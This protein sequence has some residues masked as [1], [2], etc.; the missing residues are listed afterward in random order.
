MPRHERPLTTENG[1]AAKFAAGL[2]ELRR[3]AGN[4]PYRE[5]GRR[6][7]YSAGTLSDAAAGRKLPSLSV[8]LAYVRACGGDVPEWEQRWH[9]ANADQAEP[10]QSESAGPDEHQP[11]VGLAAF[12]LDDADRFF[13]REALVDLVA[14]RVAKHRLVGVFGASGAGK[15]SLLQAGLEP[16]LA[17]G[18]VEVILFTPGPDP[19]LSY[20]AR[21]AD[22]LER[23]AEDLRAQLSADEGGLRQAVQD[24]QGAPAELILIVDQFEEVFTLGADEVARTR[25]IDALVAAA[26]AEDSR[27]RVI[28][29]VGADFY[30]HCTAHAG[31]VEMLRDAQIAVG[32]MSAAELRQAI[33]QSAHRA[34]C[35]VE[36]AL[37]AELV[38]HTHGRAGVL[39]LLS[40]ALRETWR[41]R[42]GNT[43]TV[44]GF[45]ATGGIDGALARTAETCYTSLRPRQQERNSQ[46]SL[47]PSMRSHC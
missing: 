44:A 36:G 41:R 25:F 22:V 9:E 16:W 24:R 20:A 40:H 14:H 13:G 37:V 7:H 45:Q 8:A 34:G 27:L 47:S 21:L 18:D 19:L 15:S 11:Y 29:G 23:D 46:A 42:R 35:T 31:L 3:M 28:L 17:S 10:D 1:T 39:P 32:P 43:L 38:A 5:L 30:G 6:A 12:G 2:R 4:P 33:T 26:Q